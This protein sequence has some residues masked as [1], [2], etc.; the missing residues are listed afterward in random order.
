MG[1]DAPRKSPKMANDEYKGYRIKCHI[2]S[3][4]SAVAAPPYSPVTF[5][6]YRKGGDLIHSGQVP[7]PFDSPQEAFRAG[8][9]AARKWIDA[10]AKENKK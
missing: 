6:V 2:T 9:E 5:H 8:H 1:Y 4:V 7:G 10:G 3:T